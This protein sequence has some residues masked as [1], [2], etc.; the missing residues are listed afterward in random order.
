MKRKRMIE[1]ISLSGI[2]LRMEQ[3]SIKQ[4]I[5]NDNFAMM[6]NGGELSH[7]RLREGQLYRMAEQRIVMILEGDIDMTLD[8]EE[9]HWQKGDVVLL[10]RDTILEVRR[11]SDDFDMIGI[12]F[13]PL[14]SEGRDR[15]SS[16]AL[17]DDN[18]LLH[19][20]A[21]EWREVLQMVNM[22]WA[23]A[24]HEP[25]RKKT[26]L[27]QVGTIV[28]NIHD[29]AAMHEKGQQAT[30]KLSSG[31]MLFRRFKKLVSEHC[32]QER[33]VPF[34]A[35]RLYI[36]PQHL[37]AVIKRQSGKSVMYWINRATVLHAKVLLRL[38]DIKT[39]EIANRLNFPYHSTFTKF[40]KR[41]TGISPQEYRERG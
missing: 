36:S 10:A 34:Y 16:A 40:F 17:P 14:E 18:M 32:D 8:L 1:D 4:S 7:H 38:D 29:I 3:E 25:F 21:L 30:P 9:Q 37:S 20:N 12:S 27:L 19:T 6:M 26:V 35:S 41:E 33:N 28:S 11:H 31:E 39:S 22:L 24:K 13:A 5:V 2:S 15:S 23:L